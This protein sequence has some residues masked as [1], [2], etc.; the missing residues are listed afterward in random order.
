LLSSKDSLQIGASAINDALHRNS[1]VVAKTPNQS[2]FNF[3]KSRRAFSRARMNSSIFQ[4]E[5]PDL[6]GLH[7]QHSAYLGSGAA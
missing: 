6:R 5:D 4:T 2:G 3:E 7:E 1:A